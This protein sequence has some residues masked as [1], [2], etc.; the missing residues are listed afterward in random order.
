MPAAWWNKLSIGLPPERVVYGSL[1]AEAR[2]PAIVCACLRV[3]GALE[4]AAAVVGV[5]HGMKHTHLSGNG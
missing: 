1:L 3:T 2:F 4:A 5:L